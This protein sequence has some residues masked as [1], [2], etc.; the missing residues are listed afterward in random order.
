LDPWKDYYHQCGDLVT[1]FN[2]VFCFP[3]EKNLIKKILI[4]I[5]LSSLIFL[6]NS[7]KTEAGSCTPVFPATTCSVTDSVTITATVPDSTATFTGVAPASSTVTIK[8]NTIVSGSTVTGPS[9]S[10]SK[11]IVST[12]GLHDF[13]LYLT[14]TSGRT[15]PETTYAGINLPYHVDTPISSILMPPT[16]ATSKTSILKGESLAVLGQGSP[17]STLHIILNG[18]EI[19]SETIGA[20]SD[21]NFVFNS[22]YVVGSNDV[23]SYLT[24]SGYTNSVNSFTKNFTVGNCRRSDLNC[25]GSVNLTDFSI[26]LYY[27]DSNSSVADINQDGK[28]GLIDF[29]IMMFDWTE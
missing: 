6:I 3:K 26:L 18:T 16:I 9:G 19:H 11:T 20:G 12:P 29:S 21:Y 28:V 1:L 23:Y 8:D 4:I 17:G 15:T 13:A 10:F 24:R 7:T 27:W 14:D 2:I 22:G 25:D 5:G